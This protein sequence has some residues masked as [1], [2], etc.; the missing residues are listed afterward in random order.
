MVW[1]WVLKLFVFIEA[2]NSNIAMVKVWFGYASM[3]YAIF[4]QPCCNKA[5]TFCYELGFFKC[6][7]Q[8]L[9]IWQR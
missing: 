6:L 8:G 1:H 7:D 3:N 5:T 9:N 2:T 4:F